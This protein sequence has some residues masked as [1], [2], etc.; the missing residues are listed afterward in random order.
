M[1]KFILIVILLLMVFSFCVAGAE[2]YTL[3]VLC[4]PKPTNHV[5]IRRKPKKG[6]EETGRLE[7]GDRVLTDGR[8]KNGYI[9]ILGMT[10][11]GEGWVHKGYLVDDRP[12]IEK[13]NA[14]IAASGRVMSYNRVSGKKLGWIE[15]CT[16]VRVYA[17]S[18]EWAVTSRGYIRT[19]H[20]EI[21]ID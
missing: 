14:T 4:D 6:A 15:V 5:A 19:K 13:C 8:M 10:E 21:W 17:R 20:L 16:D 1:I 18:E 2:E 3:F 7:C 9:H 11:D 12:I